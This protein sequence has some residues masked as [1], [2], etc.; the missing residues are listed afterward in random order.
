MYG[1]DFLIEVLKKGEWEKAPIS[2]EGNYGFNAIGIMLPCEEISE[3][4]I[5]WHWL[6]GE[7][8]PGEYRIGKSVDDFI[9]SGK[10]DKYMVYAHFILN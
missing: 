9:E 1:E 2:L 3:R 4:D 10:F 8:E 5:D 6:Y 7:L